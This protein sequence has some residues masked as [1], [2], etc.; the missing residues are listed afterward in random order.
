MKNIANKSESGKRT[1]TVQNPLSKQ[2]SLHY[3]RIKV[4]LPFDFV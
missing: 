3:N 4:L 1:K 2:V